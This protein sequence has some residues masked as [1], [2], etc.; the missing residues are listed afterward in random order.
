[1]KSI[2]S[3]L[4]PAVLSASLALAAAVS[5]PGQAEIQMLDRIVAVVDDSTVS[6]SELDERMSE[7]VNRTRAAGI[8]LPSISILREQVLNQLVDET[9]Q[10]NIAKRY[11]VE[12]SDEEV[13]ASIRDLMSRQGLNEAQLSQ[14]LAQEGLTLDAF[15][16]NMRR[17][18]KLQTISQGLVRQRIKISD[19]DI[20]NFLNSADAQFWIAP[21]Y[22]LQHILIPIEGSGTSAVAKAQKHAEDIYQRLQN[23][24]NFAEI[25]IAE[26][27]GP[28]ALKGGDLGLRKSSELPTL[29]ADVAPTLELGQVAEPVRSQA[30]FHIIKLLDKKG[31]TKQVVTQ[32]K[33]RHILIK[34]NEILD[35]DGARKKLLDIRKQ[36]VED[37][38]SFSVLA[39]QYSDDIGSKATGGDMGWSSPG[40]F[41]PEFEKTI[42]NSKIGVISEPFK[43]QFGWHILEVTDRR[44][45]DLS[46]EVI[47]N[48]AR[49][50][51]ISRRMEDEIQVWLQ[52]IRDE[53]FIELKI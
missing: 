7:V 52:E 10:L 35:D 40:I 16:D 3:L 20:D 48:K 39:K 33:V 44:D 22:H 23:G 53:A 21:S 15:K 32:A 49:N 13:I 51:L 36:I 5:L 24:A 27:R 6:Q 28:A 43:T 41:V 29:F 14:A 30:G 19:Q 12:I 8:T 45:E 42:E 2:T 38:K 9:L 18:L 37:G 11:G 34:T 46:D 50:L 25:A 47:R 26:S 4:K 1:M 17:Q 31:E